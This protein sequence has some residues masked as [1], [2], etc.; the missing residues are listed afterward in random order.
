VVE[1]L[2]ALGTRLG[3]TGSNREKL[4]AA[5]DGITAQENLLADRLLSWLSARND[6]HIVGRGFEGA[7]RVPTIA[8]RFDGTDSGAIAGAMDAYG[9][10]I[11]F[12]DFHSRRLVEDLNE[13]HDSGVLRVSMVHYNTLAQVDK[14]TAALAEVVSTQ[15]LA[16]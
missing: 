6:C 8:F 9:I 7:Q 13:S 5:F 1:Y 15:A 11:R 2:V 14:L 16:S 4:E 10:A 12:G 3:A